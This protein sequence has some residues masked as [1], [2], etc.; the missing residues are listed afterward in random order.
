[1]ALWLCGGHGLVAR[2]RA[3]GCVNLWK[4][5]P[6]TDVSRKSYFQQHFSRLMRLTV[7]GQ[8]E[9]WPLPALNSGI[10]KVLDNRRTTQHGRACPRPLGAF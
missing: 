1:M 3:P 6:K 9:S 8:E 5:V 4:T 7:V 10:I 2:R